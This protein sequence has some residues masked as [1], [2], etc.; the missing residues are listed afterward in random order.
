[1]RAIEYQ[2]SYVKVTVH[3]AGHEDVIAHVPDRSFFPMQV[4]RGDRVTARWSVADVH[5]LRAVGERPYEQALTAS[6]PMTL[7]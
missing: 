7:D 4:Q 5:M 2:G 6:S 3:R 1:V